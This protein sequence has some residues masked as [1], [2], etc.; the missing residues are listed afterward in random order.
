M[1]DFSK[2]DFIFSSRVELT[3][4]V[5]PKD[6]LKA[7]TEAGS[8]VAMDLGQNRRFSLDRVDS[9]RL[10]LR[11]TCHVAYRTV[12]EE[13][14]EEKIAKKPELSLVSCGLAIIQRV[15]NN[16][17]KAKALASALYNDAD[18]GSLSFAAYLTQVDESSHAPAWAPHAWTD[19]QW[20]ARESESY[21]QEQHE[22][23]DR[24]QQ[25]ASGKFQAF[26]WE[27]DPELDI[28]P[29]LSL[30]RVHFG[31]FGV[32]GVDRDTTPPRTNR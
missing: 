24:L 7:F 27:C 30:G 25:R 12:H 29:T 22:E 31:S 4:G 5:N 19:S 32:G 23:W 1:E 26:C 9:I 28:D 17:G 8:G 15:Y 3:A 18:D 14:T 13:Y 10:L 2:P 21:T 20:D 11:R 6:F 16:S